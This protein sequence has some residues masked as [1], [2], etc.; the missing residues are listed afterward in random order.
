MCGICVGIYLHIYLAIHFFKLICL[1]IY[2]MYQLTSE[3]NYY[4]F[5]DVNSQVGKNRY[6]YGYNGPVA[7]LKQVLKN[8][9]LDLFLLNL[10]W[11]YQPSQ[12][13]ISGQIIHAVVIGTWPYLWPCQNVAIITRFTQNH[14][15]Y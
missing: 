14:K 12:L 2:Y 5:M 9:S 7:Q 4:A 8:F 11:N 6:A 10:T 3:H 15:Q 13:K 1:N